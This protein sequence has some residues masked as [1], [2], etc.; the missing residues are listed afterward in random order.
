MVAEATSEY[1]HLRERISDLE[2]FITRM[3]TENAYLRQQ[4]DQRERRHRK[5]QA[6]Y[7]LNLERLIKFTDS[8][9]TNQ[10]REKFDQLRSNLHITSNITSNTLQ[11]P[12]QQQQHQVQ[13]QHLQ[14]QSQQQQNPQ[15]HIQQ[16]IQQRNNI[17]YYQPNTGYDQRNV[18]FLSY[19]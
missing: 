8:I 1:G 19:S 2:G 15:P 5:D 14:Q 7:E 11:Q 9:V 4:V 18:Y 6:I 12:Q 10:N 3:E 17:N 16:N 13:P